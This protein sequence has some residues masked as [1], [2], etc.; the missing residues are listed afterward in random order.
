MVPVPPHVSEGAT[1]VSEGIR[2]SGRYEHADLAMR[3]WRE[4]RN[5]MGALREREGAAGNTPEMIELACELQAGSNVRTHDDNRAAVD[6]VAAEYAEVLAPYLPSG[7]RVIDAGAGELTMLGAVASRLPAGHRSWLACDLSWS[8]LH[9]GRAFLASRP[10]YA[11]AAG[12][13]CFV[14]EMGRLPLADSA[15]DVALTFHALQPNRGREAELVAE[16]TRVAARWVVL[17]EP[18]WE[19]A[20]AEARRRMDTHGYVRGLAGAIAAAGG[21]LVDEIPIRAPLDPLYPTV[22]RV[23]RPR[24]PGRGAVAMPEKAMWRCP[25]SGGELLRVDHPEGSW[26]WSPAPLLLYPVVG[27]IPLLTGSSALFAARGDA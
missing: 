27:G 13:G 11:A 17:F 1:Q 3:A 24:P 16:L 9:V 7:T 25:V 21:E 20:D 12:A 8:R 22:A 5:V 15:V 14:A 19:H 6:R 10:E 18:S 2:R 4:G 23:V 26:L